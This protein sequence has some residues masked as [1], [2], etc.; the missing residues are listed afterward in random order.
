MA[1]DARVRRNNPILAGICSNDP[2][3]EPEGRAEPLSAG[4]DF[5]VPSEC[6]GIVYGLRETGKWMLLVDGACCWGTG[7][8]WLGLTDIIARP[9]RVLYIQLEGPFDQ[10]EQRF[11]AWEVE[12]GNT[13]IYGSSVLHTYAPGFDLTAPDARDTL[14][15]AISVDDIDVLIVD[16][17]DAG[18]PDGSN[19]VDSDVGAIF[20]RTLTPI[21]AEWGTTVVLAAHANERTLPL[22]GSAGRRTTPNGWSTSS[23]A[24]GTGSPSSTSRRTSQAS[25]GSRST[26]PIRRTWILSPGALS[27]S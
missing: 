4:G 2:Y 26:S 11:R 6:L 10:V 9:R 22:A 23:I 12:H 7:T 19:M 16:T 8:P 15:E 3:W 1:K 14:E 21:I 17:L 18:R 20:V 13:E 24:V 27:A 25:P 5:I